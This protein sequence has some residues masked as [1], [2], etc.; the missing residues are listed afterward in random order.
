[1][2]RDN[3]LEKTDAGKDWRLED[4]GSVEDETDSITNSMDM[5]WG[6]SGTEK[7]G[8]L[9]SIGLQRVGHDLMAEQQT[10]TEEIRE[11]I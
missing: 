3:S 9:H 8:M 4:K 5:I 7:P 2:Q 10:T 1:M 6:N 11:E